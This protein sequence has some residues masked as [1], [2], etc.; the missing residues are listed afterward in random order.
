VAE[1]LLFALV[2]DPLRAIA[3]LL[4]DEDRFRARL[5]CRTLRDHADAAAAP[6][7]RAAF[8]RT[9]ALAAYA[10]DAAPR[11]STGVL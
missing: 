2:G 6:I 7:S 4:P 11:T 10:C 9:R 1:P 8:L 5:A 3:R